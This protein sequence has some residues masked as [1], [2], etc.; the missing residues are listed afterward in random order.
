MNSSFDINIYKNKLS[1]FG[2]KVLRGLVEQWHEEK[3]SIYKGH[4]RNEV[5]QSNQAFRDSNKRVKNSN[6]Q[7]DSFDS[8]EQTAIS[9]HRKKCTLKFL[10]KE[11]PIA[12]TPFELLN[13]KA[14]VEKNDTILSRDNLV[15]SAV[16]F[17]N[18]STHTYFD[19]QPGLKII[20]DQN[21]V[22]KRVDAIPVVDLESPRVSPINIKDVSWS[23][24][25]DTDLFQD[26][27]DQLHNNESS[28]ECLT[29]IGDKEEVI[30]VE[31]ETVV[32]TFKKPNIKRKKSD[33]L[34]K[35]KPKKEKKLAASNTKN[36]KI[37]REENFKKVVKNWLNDVE[38]NSLLNIAEPD[39]TEPILI[40]DK[41]ES[42]K[43]VHP[44]IS[45]SKE[46]TK[47]RVVQAQLANKEGKMKF[48]KPTNENAN[49]D[50]EDTAIDDKRGK[51]FKEVIKEKKKSKFVAPIKSQT[52]VKDQTY[53]ILSLDSNNLEIHA[54]TLTDIA[55]TDVFLVITYR[56]GFC[57]LN[58]NYTEDSCVSEGILIHAN[59]VFF[60]FKTFD[61]IHLRT[62][63]AKVLEANTIVCFDGKSALIFLSLLD[64]NVKPLAICD[65]KIGGAL[66]DPDNP[67][68]SFA[69]LQKLV[70][71]AAEYTIATDC[72]LQKAA[73]YTTLLR[74]TTSKLRD[75]LIEHSLTNI[76]DN[77]E[78][79]LLPIIAGN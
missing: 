48:R 38:S 74:E 5:M 58:C 69:D 15:M 57:Q 50:K 2:Q 68:E 45:I 4:H 55:N 76:F 11:N 54:N 63:L 37:S 23:N 33:N 30:L 49:D 44:K 35:P 12:S 64:I 20:T 71:H 28:K 56:N 9:Y 10:E 67:P 21:T 26:S 46:K 13:Y 14:T 72:A 78:M 65:T 17:N 29:A 43:V 41:E 6:Y 75:L 53:E 31:P 22:E 24:M 51:D 66:L 61:S 52:P 18:H 59:D 73:W 16:E 40:N 70:S 62:L 27:I 34:T 79:R 60:F 39:T 7:N 42:D 1:L 19:G 25:F 77:V 36:I 47:K 3:A 8:F 32:E